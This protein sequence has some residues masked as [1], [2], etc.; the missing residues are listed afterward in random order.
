[1]S[2]PRYCRKNHEV[3]FEKEMTK[4][5]RLTK[6][7]NLKLLDFAWKSVLVRLPRIPKKNYEERVWLKRANIAVSMAFVSKNRFCF[8]MLTC[9]TALF[10]R[11]AMMEIALTNLIIVLSDF[12]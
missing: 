7:I 11:R 8:G 4:K 5:E 3:V 12:V 9:V 6:F 10:Y 1:M 2:Y